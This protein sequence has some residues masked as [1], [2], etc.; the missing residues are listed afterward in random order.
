MA[1]HAHVKRSQRADR[2]APRPLHTLINELSLLLCA[3]RK[4]FHRQR[5][6]HDQPRRPLHGAAGPGSDSQISIQIGPGEREDQR[7][8]GMQPAKPSH[9]W[10]T[11]P[12]VQGDQEIAR[13]IVV[14]WSH[15]DS[16]AE[17]AEDASPSRRGDP[18]ASSAL[19]IG[20][21]DDADFHGLCGRP[22]VQQG[23]GTRSL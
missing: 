1:Q 17:L 8:V 10:I 15:D 2:F 18:V 14:A 23:G 9:G 12:G 3:S 5:M 4:R 19:G 20:W 13:L 16:M 7:C 22:V 21:C 11:A 6:Q